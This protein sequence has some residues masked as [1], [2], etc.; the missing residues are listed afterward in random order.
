MALMV[1]VSFAQ[2][3][4]PGLVNLS[5]KVPQFF[6]SS[7]HPYQ[8]ENSYLLSKA[9]YLREK[10]I[11][12][13][14]EHVKEFIL[15]REANGRAIVDVSDDDIEYYI[16][17]Q[18]G[19]KSRQ[20]NALSWNTVNSRIGGAHRF[21]IWC[22][23]NG[24]N[25]HITLEK[26]P[27]VLGRGFQQYETKTHPSRKFVEPTKFLHMDL[28]IH[29][30]RVLNETSALCARSKE[31]NLL[32]AKLMLQCGL[33]VSEAVNFPVCDLPVINHA[34]HSTPAR[35]VGK[36]GKARFILIPNGLLSDLWAYMDISREYIVDKLSEKNREVAASLFISEHGKTL[37]VNWIEK[38]FV[39]VAS[40]MGIW[41]VPHTL[42]HTFGTYHYLY[43]RDLVML[44][45]LMGH[46][47]EATTEK[48]YVNVANLVAHAES[49]EKLQISLDKSCEEI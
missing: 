26:A 20:G 41:A 15:W 16:A 29:F 17:A 8:I 34:G 7:G 47:S 22:K 46:E 40:R 14:A 23:S 24:F 36:G 28:A 45:Q 30:L 37:T 21:L 32:M 4:Q 39:R 25:E 33:R 18:C 13:T 10:S 11:I 1:Y 38:L 3:A 12:T 5:Y 9:R 44:S 6:K 2:A 48:F 42:R 31:R 19:Y 49:Y 43:N 27:A 35:I